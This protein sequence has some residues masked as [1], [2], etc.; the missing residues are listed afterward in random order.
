L[1]A[2][3]ALERA[4]TWWHERSWAELR[5]A[6]AF[7]A[8][9]LA[10]TLLPIRGDAAR[11]EEWTNQQDVGARWAEHGEHGRAIVAFEHALRLERAAGHDR[12]STPAIVEARALLAFNYAVALHQAGRAGEALHWFEAAARDDPDNARFIRTLADAYGAAGRAREAD[13]LAAKLGTLVGGEPQALIQQGWQA[14]R[15]ARPAAAESLFT[16]ATN[17]DQNQF[18]AWMALVRVQVERDELPAAQST[19]ERAAQ[20]RVPEDMLWA[21]RALVAAASGDSAR[22]QAALAR[23][24]PGSITGNRLLESVIEDAQQRLGRNPR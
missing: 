21:H 15:E 13:S 11:F 9:A 8:A 10:L 6:S 1:L 20:L 17:L 12:D 18:G 2:A 22:A 3:L 5:R 24:S 23:I 16:L 14:M 4:W 19:L 7:A